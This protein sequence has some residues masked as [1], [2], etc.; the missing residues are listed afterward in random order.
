M[1]VR[2]CVAVS[3]LFVHA[4]VSAAAAQTLSGD[5]KE[6]A[7]Y[8]LTMPTVKKVA[9]VTRALAEIE[10]KDPAVQELTKVRAEL[11]VLQAKEEM[12]EAEGER[13]EKLTE[14]EE[15]L[16]AQIDSRDRNAGPNDTLDDMV[17]RLQKEPAAMAVLA[18]EGLAP[19]EYAK[20][21][22]ALLQVALVEGFSEGKAELT[23]LPPGINPENVKFVRENKAVLEDMKT[24]FD[25][26]K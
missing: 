1:L 11:K 23:K 12:T 10:Q 8:R 14:R 20:C 18:R 5:E 25:A 2:S 7:S 6:L 16:E 17:A 3:L 19:R 24:M 22:L 9:A 15:Q 4:A 26:S 21:L 13:I